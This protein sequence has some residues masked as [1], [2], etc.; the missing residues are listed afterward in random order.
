M[1]LWY[2][3]M[4]HQNNSSVSKNCSVCG[5]LSVASASK[6]L[7]PNDEMPHSQ[8]NINQLLSSNYTQASVRPF[9]DCC[10]TSYDRTKTKVSRSFSHGSV[11]KKIVEP[12]QSNIVSDLASQSCLT[13]DSNSNFCFG[14][15]S[16]SWPC[17]VCTLINHRDF[18]KCEVCE[19]PRKSKFLS[20]TFS[21]IGLVVSFPELEKES[22]ESVKISSFTHKSVRRGSK[23]NMSQPSFVPD[24]VSESNTRFRS[25]QFKSYQSSNTSIEL[26][27]TPLNNL[28]LLIDP[29][30]KLK[31]KY[32]YIGISDPKSLDLCDEPFSKKDSLLISSS[33]SSHTSDYKSII[34][35]VTISKPCFGSLKSHFCFERMWSCLTCSFSYNPIKSINC[36]VCDSVRGSSCF[37]DK[38]INHDSNVQMLSVNDN[39]DLD[40]V[41]LNNDHKLLPMCSDYCEY[42]WTCKKCTLVNSAIAVICAACGGS[43]HSSLI[44]LPDKNF[45]RGSWVCPQCTLKNRTNISVCKACKFFNKS[46]NFPSTSSLRQDDVKHYNHSNNCKLVSSLSVENPMNSLNHP[47]FPDFFSNLSNDDTGDKS[48]QCLHCTFENLKSSLVCEMCLISRHNTLTNDNHPAFISSPFTRIIKEDEH[49]ENLRIIEENEALTKW[50]HILKYCME[51]KSTS[52]IFFL[53]V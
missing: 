21:S 25:E 24:T 3:Q 35:P 22:S 1:T 51:V 37:N 7:Q 50:K 15:R 13:T 48:W 11:C 46:L 14:L 42:E 43:K 36:E 28:N 10:T 8:Q 53:I 18:D 47:Y 39:G 45:G 32:S 31:T 9:K 16:E 44:S 20:T 27:K 17:H 49:L 33:S 2:C 12:H 6:L 5:A 26:P 38:K 23:P 34:S 19:T 41:Y 30:N 40:T 4:C 29:I 52:C